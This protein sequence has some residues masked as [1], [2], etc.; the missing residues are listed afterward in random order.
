MIT[1]SCY[2]SKIYLKDTYYSVKIHDYY[3][4]FSKHL[5]LTKLYK[6]K[7]FPNRLSSCQSEIKMCTSLN[8]SV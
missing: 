8:T 2:I 7:C 4:R 1:K 5:N 6:F 3:K